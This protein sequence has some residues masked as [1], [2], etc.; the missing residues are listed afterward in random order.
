MAGSSRV[1]KSRTADAAREAR[2]AAVA[3]LSMRER[4]KLALNLGRRAKALKG[5]QRG[6]R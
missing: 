3:G 6:L 2:N 1:M 4:I 5:K